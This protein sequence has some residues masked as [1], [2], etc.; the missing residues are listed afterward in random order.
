MRVEPIAPGL[1]RWASPHPE[2]TED[3]GGLGGWEAEVASIYVEGK[4][5]VALI[6]PL[7]PIDPEDRDR[8]WRALDRDLARLPEV[9]LMV[10]V[11]SPWH[12]R[13]AAEFAERYRERPGTA[14]RAHEEA[15]AFVAELDARP[16]R[17]G[18]ALPG[19]VR[20]H[21]IEGPDP[22]ECA[23]WIPD[24]RALVFA[25]AVIGAGNGEL[26]LCPPSWLAA[27]EEGRERHASQLRPSIRSLVDL[28]PERVLPSHGAPVLSGG[29][30]ALAAAVVA[31]PWGE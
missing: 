7:V 30:A 14:I 4:D 13:S 18:D 3:K 12:R 23:F 8:F 9:P 15:A 17:E 16:F 2:W 19:G 5:G 31:P 6:D 20:P 21:R 22:A 27:G 24:H 28:G 29:A 25:D 11:S 10:L 26:R 1:W